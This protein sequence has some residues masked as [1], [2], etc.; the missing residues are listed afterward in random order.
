MLGTED[1]AHNPIS[2]SPRV[3]VY[4]ALREINN[5]T[6]GV[7]D[8][9]LPGTLLHFAYRDSKCDASKSLTATLHLTRE[10]FNGQGVSAIIGAACSGASV[11]A[12][13]VAGGSF[14][15]I[16]SPTAVSSTLSNGK[17]YPYFLR[18]IP[19]DAFSSIAMADVLRTLFGYTSVAMVHS[20]DAYGGGG[21]S[22]FAAAA[23]EEGITIVSTQ[24]F[25]KDATDFSVQ[26]QALRKSAA[27]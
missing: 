12:A 23:E 25:T 24:I 17:G 20:D 1:A 13:Q 27:R 5:K 18:V 14:V 9:L 6:D 11:T 7:A 21:G 26:Q 8:L 19:S 22:T 2:W 15:P 16:V 3:G 10:A 4:Q